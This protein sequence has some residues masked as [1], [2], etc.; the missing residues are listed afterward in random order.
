MEAKLALICTSLK[1]VGQVKKVSNDLKIPIEIKIGALEEAI[2][3]G[4]QLEID[5][6]EAI[7]CRDGTATMLRENL[8]IPVISIPLFLNFELL[9]HV[10]AAA[11]FGRN[12]GICVYGHR[13]FGINVLENLLGVKIRQ[14]VYC[15]SKNLRAGIIRAKKEGVHS[16]IGGLFASEICGGIGIQCIQFALSEE[17]IKR[18]INEAMAAASINR[19]EKGKARRFEA[20][21]ASVS[22]GMI[23]INQQG[24]VSIFNPVAEEILGVKGTIGVHID[25]IIPALGLSEILHTGRPV[26]QKLQIIGEIQ[27]ISNLVPV[28]LGE[29][30]VGAIASFCDISKVMR[31]EHKVRSSFTKGFVTKYTVADII[32]EDH[33]M[34][35]LIEQ[36]RRFARSDSTIL[37]TGE[38]GTGKELVSH[39]IHN[40]SPRKEEPFVTMNCSALPES[41]IESELFGHEDGAFTGARKGGKPGLFELAHKGTIFL[42]EVGSISEAVQSRLLR[43]LQQKEVMRIGGNRIIPVDVRIIAATN[44]D[45]LKTVKDGQLRMDL[46][47]RL[48]ILRLHIPPI[49]ERKKDIPVLVMSILR[50]YARKYGK[51]IEPFTDTL[52]KKFL[53]YSWPGNV[54]EIE[55][56]IEK[57]VLM[58]D[59]RNHYED[60]VASL[61]EECERTEKELFHGRCEDFLAKEKNERFMIE[62]LSKRE[63]IAKRMGISRTTLWRRLRVK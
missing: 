37:L 26:L 59:T 56:F 39:C 50:K 63:E 2:P 10:I 17:T 46:Y 48:N 31:A 52:M 33:S 58:V 18:A 25:S 11:K 19:E 36:M 47:F 44:S 38:S 3:L 57:F 30:L 13:L 8:S 60:I 40:L 49:R 16:I 32:H 21:L 12:V 23:A 22:E 45:L 1:M 62:S 51:K 34:K 5:G 55:N 53:A 24:I 9:E 61:F 28:F 6:T 42:D 7:I 4:K 35:R 14:I 54:R 27:I 29:Q 20:I 41:L 15:D 43:V